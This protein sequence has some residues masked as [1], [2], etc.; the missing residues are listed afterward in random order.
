[1][2][3]VVGLNVWLDVD[4]VQVFIVVGLNVDDDQVPHF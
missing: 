4:D 3:I 2:L 1:M